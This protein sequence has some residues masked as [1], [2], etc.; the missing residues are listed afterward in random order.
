MP[1]TSNGITIQRAKIHYLEDGLSTAP[2]ILLLHG[3]S[4]SSQTWQELNTLTLLASKGYRAVALDLPGFGRSEQASGAPGEFLIEAIDTLH[5]QQ[6]ILVAPSMSGR[7]SLPVIATQP[8]KLTGFVA[9]APVGIAHF[10][11]QLKGNKL[12][13]LAI[14]GSNDR[15]IPVEQADLLCKLMPQAQ[16]VVLVGAGHA[17]YMKATDEFHRHLLAFTRACHGQ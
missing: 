10:E 11:K 6:P 17:S 5:L 15:I 2:P 3:A 4:F 16:K 7:Y 13:T 1:T 9:V 12:A 14:W 8:D